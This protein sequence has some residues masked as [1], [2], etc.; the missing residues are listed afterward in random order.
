MAAPAAAAPSRP[1]RPCESGSEGGAGLLG[2]GLDP[3]WSPRTRGSAGG[4]QGLP[5]LARGFP[6]RPPARQDGWLCRD[7]LSQPP[8]ERC[9]ARTYPG[10]LLA[11]PCLVL[12]DGRR[13]GG[14]APL[15]EVSLAHRVELPLAL[16]HPDWAHACLLLPSLSMDLIGKRYQMAGRLP[17]TGG[18]GLRRCCGGCKPP[19]PGGGEQGPRPPP[20]PPPPTPGGVPAG[21]H[22]PP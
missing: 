8:V 21:Q 13:E 22:V 4:S 3:R 17:M 6:P 16:E 1:R 14:E 15:D 7:D 9:V 20:P 2:G 19:P 12:A 18:W 5:S 11:H 10:Q